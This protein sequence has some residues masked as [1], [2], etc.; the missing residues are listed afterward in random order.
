VF[1]PSA[2][3]SLTSALALWLAAWPGA[4]VAQ[5]SIVDTEA[6]VTTA[7]F[8]A[9]ATQAAAEKLANAKI[10]NQRAAILVLEAK[11]RAGE[12]KRAQLVAAEKDFVAE[13]AAKDREYAAQIAIFRGAVTDI[14][15][16]PQGGAALA[17]F[18]NG[19]EVGALAILD[20]L[21]AAND[22]MRQ[23][24]ADVESAAEG[25]RIAALALEARTRGKETT[26]A[27]IDRY[28]EVVRLDPALFADWEQ[29]DLL[30]QDA[31]RD[32]DARRAAEQAIQLAADD[33]DH[34]VGS[35]DLGDIMSAQGDLL[36]AAKADDDALA[37][38]RRLAGA[39]PAN[40]DL[41]HDLAISWLRVASVLSLQGHLAAARTD[42]EQSLAI[43]R[44]LAGSEP[45]KPEDQ[46]AVSASL[47]SVAE[48]MQ[49]QGDLAAAREAYDEAWK[50]TDTWPQQT[51]TIPSSNATSPSA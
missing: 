28:E 30:Y 21:R 4:A 51:P 27:V 47:S 25:R 8:A 33:R 40:A 13:L 19:D 12:A 17:Q 42:A 2:I 3:T 39:Q 45:S 15:S 20:K 34:A 44:R 26:Q 16:T 24:R 1:R 50:S 7:V 36:G 29:L 6:E 41:Q 23:Q 9:A 10:T 49:A 22:R 48:T 5:T 35:R 18:N 46:R 43:D 38:V 14:A 31:G 37:T 32:A 11:V